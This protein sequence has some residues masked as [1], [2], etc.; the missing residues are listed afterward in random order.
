MQGEKE[1]LTDLMLA[2]DSAHGEEGKI[3]DQKVA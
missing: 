2:L 1:A 3:G